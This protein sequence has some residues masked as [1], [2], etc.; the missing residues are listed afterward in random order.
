MPGS[1][2]RRAFGVRRTRELASVRE[3][4]RL[5]RAGTRVP[6]LMLL[7]A[8]AGCSSGSGSAGH[9]PGHSSGSVRPS[10]PGS[11]PPPSWL[12]TGPELARLLPPRSGL[13]PGWTASHDA[14]ATRNLTPKFSKPLAELGPTSDENNCIE[15]NDSLSAQSLMFLWEMSWAYASAKPPHFPALATPAVVQIADFLPGGAVKQLAWDRALAARCHHYR[16]PSDHS[17]ITVTAAP[18]S[19]LGDQALYVQVVNPY[20]FGGE[21]VRAHSTA[22]AVR[23]G[24][25][26]IAVSQDGTTSDPTDKVIPLS[27]LKQLAGKYIGSVSHLRG[28]SS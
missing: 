1:A 24:Q 15:L 8:V 26:M 28:N 4:R 19:G 21:L 10:S 22:L 7:V 11:T 6:A 27:G 25:D 23:V 17:P 2:G 3:V 16:D 13:P 9:S 5:R 18:V 12:P 20:H 14:S